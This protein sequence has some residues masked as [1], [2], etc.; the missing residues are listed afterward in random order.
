MRGFHV[1]DKNDSNLYALEIV[2]Q[3]LVSSE[4]SDYTRRW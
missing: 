2:N 4:S 3:L 1:G